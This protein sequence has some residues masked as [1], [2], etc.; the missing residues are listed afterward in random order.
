MAQFA[1]LN[2]ATILVVENEALVRLEVGD[3][4]AG[5][6]FIVLAASN[7][8]EAIALLD[9]HP[10]IEVLFTDVTMPGS[11]DG[12]RLAHHVRGRWPPVKIIVASGRLDAA[13]RELPSGSFFLR[14]PYA[15]EALADALAQMT[16]G[17]G[18]DLSSP[19]TSR[20]A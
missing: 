3:R 11:M 5:L 6:G 4:L 12:V 8:D 16:L 20:R 13:L 19:Q 1:R 14:K 9:V 15:P 17:R 2:P 7:A 10:E 18:P